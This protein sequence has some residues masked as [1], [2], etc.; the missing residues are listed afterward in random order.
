MEEH[1]LNEHI[2]NVL[3]RLKPRFQTRRIRQGELDFQING[4]WPNFDVYV[5]L[6]Q[7]A[8]PPPPPPP[9]YTTV[10]HKPAGFITTAELE[11][12]HNKAALITKTLDDFGCAI[13]PPTTIHISEP[14]VLKSGQHL[15]GHSLK[16]IIKPGPGYQG[17]LVE[18]FD[19]ENQS[20][21]QCSIRNLTLDGNNTTGT[22]LRLNCQH[23]TFQNLLI[24]SCWDYGIHI[25]GHSEDMTTGLAQN[26]S[27][28]S[29][30]M[31]RTND[32]SMWCGLLEDD[33][34]AHNSILDCYIEQCRETCIETRGYNTHILNCFL[35][36][37]NNYG[38][39]VRN[40]QKKII[41]ACYIENTDNNAIALF[42]PC[43]DVII[44]NNILH[45]IR[46]KT[47]S[48]LPG[49]DS[50]IACY[51]TPSNSL[52]CQNLVSKDNNNPRTVPN[53]LNTS[54]LT[55]Y[56]NTWTD[57]V[58]EQPPNPPLTLKT[59]SGNHT[60]L[61][62]HHYVAYGPD[63]TLSLPAGTPN[64]IILLTRTVSPATT[65]T[66]APL[67]T[68]INN[69]T[70]PLTLTGPGYTTLLFESTTTG[71]RIT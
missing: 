69:S 26:N 38:L 23:S 13:L 14:I 53:F 67:N 30:Y 51:T 36:Q 43:E 37:S 44:S 8:P 25:R 7:P 28:Q 5:S 16:T 47:T 61:P 11:K 70:D 40:S 39:V 1:I 49:S 19:Y 50:I 55:T 4:E 66:L 15:S 31:P 17:H 33:Y 58:Q 46:R 35:R 12:E 10:E 21:L 64:Q 65:L 54:N 62:N 48:Q 29:V 24:T 2:L 32:A 63:A 68:K 56:L 20:T 42:G 27:F 52:I 6:P 22:A 3:R 18:T 41:S 71:W 9:V 45:N 57:A 59:I 34:T 60:L